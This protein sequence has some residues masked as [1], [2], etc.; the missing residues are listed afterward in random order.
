MYDGSAPINGIGMCH[1]SFR[2]NEERINR[3][4]SRDRRSLD[5]AKVSHASSV[6]SILAMALHFCFGAHKTL[7]LPFDLLGLGRP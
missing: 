6:A 2:R 5:L 4:F 3:D 7:S 1:V